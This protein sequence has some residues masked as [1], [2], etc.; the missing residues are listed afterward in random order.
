MAK[1]TLSKRIIVQDIPTKGQFYEWVCQ[2]YELAQLNSERM[3]ADTQ[4][5]AYSARM[6]LKPL[7]ATHDMYRLSGDIRATI[8]VVCGLS[9]DVFEMDINAPMEVDYGYNM[10]SDENTDETYLLPEP[11]E[12]GTIDIYESCI[13][14]LL[15]ALPT[16]PVK[17][18]AWFEYTPNPKKDIM[19]KNKKHSPFDVLRT[20]KEK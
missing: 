6:C 8:M 13:Q 5:K 9:S 15:L 1:V 12:N 18:G 14:E 19:L 7:L 10:H 3:P 4:I 20:L 17:Q 16:N 2:E 11:I